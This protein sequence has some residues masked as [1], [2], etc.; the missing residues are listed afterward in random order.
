MNIKET[1]RR[2]SA[3]IVAVALIAPNNSVQ[4]AEESEWIVRA[5]NQTSEPAPVQE[6][7]TPQPTHNAAEAAI[8]QLSA[9]DL[10]WIRSSCSR[11]P[12]PAFWGN[13]AKRQLQA[14]KAGL[15]EISELTWE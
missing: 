3:I 6:R 9:G 5:D 15:P 8:T 13:C 7:R 4:A 12:G 11:N 1:S 14:I 10:A 2:L